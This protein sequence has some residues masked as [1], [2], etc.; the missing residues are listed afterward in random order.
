MPTFV[1]YSHSDYSDVWPILFGQCH[2]Y[3]FGYKKVLITN[4]GEA[5]S[6][7]VTVHYDEGQKY[8]LRVCSG[9]EQITDDIIVFHH[10]D[11]ILYD[12]ID[13]SAIEDFAKIVEPYY[14]FIGSVFIRLLRGGNDSNTR[15]AE[16]T[17]R[18]I[19]CD[20]SCYQIQPTICKRKDLLALYYAT[21]G[22]TI[23][24]FEEN[25]KQMGYHLGF[26]GLMAYQETDKKRG[27]AHWD[28]KVYPFIATAVVKGKWNISEYPE[29]SQLLS[30]YGIDPTIRGT[31]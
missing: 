3:L 24:A 9:L 25:T 4:K 27:Q 11:M 7:W 31:R 23:W 12:K 21:K 13:N 19:F 14:L 29:L 5:P 22:T 18:L 6:D 30:E 17:K 8:Q 26:K 15:P 28:S 2:K 20:E 1:F 10:E 16:A